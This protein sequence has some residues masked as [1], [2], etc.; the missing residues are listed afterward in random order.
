ME[1]IRAEAASRWVEALDLPAGSAPAADV[2]TPNPAFAVASGPPP[3][4]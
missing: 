3:G 2:H 1:G 4:F